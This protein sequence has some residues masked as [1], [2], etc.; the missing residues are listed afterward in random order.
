MMSN[1][2]DVLYHRISN[3]SRTA[4]TALC[5]R[6]ISAI[7]CSTMRWGLGSSGLRHHSATPLRPAQVTP[8]WS[9]CFRDESRKL[10]GRFG[11]QTMLSS[12]AFVE[13]KQPLFRHVRKWLVGSSFVTKWGRKPR[14]E[15]RLDLRAQIRG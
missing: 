1:I 14:P 5:D 10:A 6:W 2:P 4:S 8:H 9:P 12:I 11:T 15:Q 3:A 13:V 7:H